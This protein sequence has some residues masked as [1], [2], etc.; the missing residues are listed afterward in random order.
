ML[1]G[2]HRFSVGG[3]LSWLRHSVR[4]S[5]C[6]FSTVSAD[7]ESHPPAAVEERSVGKSGPLLLYGKL[8]SSGRLRY[9]PNQ[10][11]ALEKLQELHDLIHDGGGEQKRAE[12]HHAG[13]ATDFG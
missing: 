4:P 10:R 2:R 7:E 8:V 9:D 13:I 5:R 6:S 11:V 1:P 12:S 3:T